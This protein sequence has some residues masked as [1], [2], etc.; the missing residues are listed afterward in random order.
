MKSC[1]VKNKQTHIKLH[2]K[3]VVNK[4][5]TPNSKPNYYFASI[6]NSLAEKYECLSK[7][8]HRMDKEKA[9]W[10]RQVRVGEG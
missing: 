2:K 3:S 8:E 4:K 6:D 10:V 1:S 5:P 7:T 9:S